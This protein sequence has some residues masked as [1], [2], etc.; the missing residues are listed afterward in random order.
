M[1][2]NESQSHIPTEVY[3]DFLGRTIPI[4]WSY[5]AILMAGIWFVL[6]PLCIL[7]IRYGKPK[8][9]Q[10]GIREEISHSAFACVRRL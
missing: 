2:M 4:H 1:T 7:A 6:V 8:P 5:H 3:F 10:Y 9:T